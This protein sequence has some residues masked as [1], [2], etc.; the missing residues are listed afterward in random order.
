MA[1]AIVIEGI[2]GL[3]ILFLID[4]LIGQPVQGVIIRHKEA[5]LNFL[6]CFTYGTSLLTACFVGVA[7]FVGACMIMSPHIAFPAPIW[8]EKVVGGLLGCVASIAG[9]GMA[10]LIA[11]P[12]SR[13]L[14][15]N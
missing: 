2:I 12:L 6:K 4:V 8:V 13:V 1:T 15:I 10:V 14:A 5:I 11:K 7:I 3:C 9:I